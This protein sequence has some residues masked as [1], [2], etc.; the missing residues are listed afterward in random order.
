MRECGYFAKD[1]FEVLNSAQRY[2]FDTRKPLV[3]I[4]TSIDVI[5]KM[6]SAIQYMDDSN[7]DIGYE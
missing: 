1:V 5:S 3:A 6:I 4:E 2:Y 7:G